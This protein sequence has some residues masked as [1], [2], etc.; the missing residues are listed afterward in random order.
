MLPDAHKQAK[1]APHRTESTSLSKRQ[2]ALKKLPTRPVFK[3]LEIAEVGARD[4]LKT[5]HNIYEATCAK[6]NEWL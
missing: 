4:S 1:Q 5:R 2:R 6:Q 3:L